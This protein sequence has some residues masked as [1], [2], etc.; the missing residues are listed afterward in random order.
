MA[1]TILAIEDD[2]DLQQYLTEILRDLRYSVYTAA[3]GSKGLKYLDKYNPDLI[4]LDLN[5]PDIEGESLLTQ[6][7][8]THPNLPIIVLTGK[9]KTENITQNLNQGADD[10]VTKP[11]SSEELVARIRARLRE[12]KDNSPILKAKDLTLNAE[13]IEVKRAGKTII[14]TQTEFQ[15]LKY[16]LEN[17]N[18]VLSRD[19]ILGHVWSAAPEVETRVEDVYIG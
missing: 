8:K 2:K 1:S 3:T 15:L 5:L 7:K 4:L 13:T 19:M 6:I 10:Y 9:D 18:R 17:K 16:L 12:T 11:F 14:L